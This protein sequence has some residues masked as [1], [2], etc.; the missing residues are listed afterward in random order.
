MT[1]KISDNQSTEIGGTDRM[2]RVIWAAST[3]CFLVLCLHLPVG[4]NTQSAHDDALFWNRAVSIVNG[5]WLGPYNNK[6]LSKGP[7]FSLFL[8]FNHLVGLPVTLAVAAL[9]AAACT[10]F[11]RSVR[12]MGLPPLLALL[13]Y[14]V[15]L[16]EPALFPTR[17][18][19]DNIYA[20]LTLL[21]LGSSIQLLCNPASYRY[22]L[23]GG[24]S[25][26][27]FTMT[28]DEGIWIAPGLAVIATAILI[29]NLRGF[30]PALDWR[31]FAKV[32][33]VAAVSFAIPTI[34]V[35]GLNYWY[36]GFA[37][38]VDFQDRN[39][40]AA[41]R[42]LQSVVVGS[43]VPYLPVPE[44]SRHLIYEQSPTFKE[45]ENYFESKGRGWT[46]HG[47]DIYPHTAGDYAGGW[48]VWALRDAVATRGHYASPEKA[49]KF[50]KKLADEI[51]SAQK[52][53]RLPYRRSAISFMPI[54]GPEAVTRIP[55]SMVK[56]VGVTCY[57]DSAASLPELSMGPL[58]KLDAMKEFLGNPRTS[59]VNPSIHTVRGW[60]KSAQGEWLQLRYTDNQ[61]EPPLAIARQDSPD[62]VNHFGDPAF[63]RNRYNL[64]FDSA[65]PAIL[66]TDDRAASIPTQK[67][68]EK[69]R[70]RILL[71]GGVLLVEEIGK[72][73]AL[74]EYRAH[75]IKDILTQFYRLITL[76]MLLG[77]LFLSFVSAVLAVRR[78]DRT[79]ETHYA[80]F[81]AT[82]L[83]CAYFSRIAVCVL[84]DISSF[85][86]IDVLYLGCVFPLIPAF[87]F[88]SVGA[89]IS[90]L[91]ATSRT[92]TRLPLA[93]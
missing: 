47:T 46:K 59:A 25:L 11:A 4:I 85:P 82:A 73:P 48:F 12:K 23:L 38:T 60:F 36:Y 54:I 50:F 43:P 66:E 78:D 8:A 16:F 29:G 32:I 63:A 28:R 55:L 21:V 6:T 74:S 22:A 68:T 49:S 7:F 5:D 89:L 10:V 1:S 65:R 71:G 69:K 27:A 42:A 34:G 81:V 2:V 56:A 51:R 75:K 58:D 53:D 67:L 76:P 33:A 3:L 88:V 9:Y 61:E 41:V 13:L 20:S 31:T 30:Y 83:L 57:K 91:Q 93:R 79:P 37:G 87:A 14:I 35:I 84:V 52:E 77:G 19:R 64:S 62:L 86:G 90:C 17:I 15:M 72:P 24:F 26:A 45:L 92:T 44:A 40:K 80:L 70:N 39:F 18:V